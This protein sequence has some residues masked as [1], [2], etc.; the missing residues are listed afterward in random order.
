MSACGLFPA[1]GNR[2]PELPHHL[3]PASPRA[4]QP[5]I[6]AASM[7]LPLPYKLTFD[8]GQEPNRL[9][10]PQK[11]TSVPAFLPYGFTVPLHDPQ[12][13]FRMPFQALPVKT[14]R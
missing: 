14:H 3:K 4:P 10:N 8:L 6:A 13:G 9:F 12:F 11:L 5:D 2:R 7:P 1:T